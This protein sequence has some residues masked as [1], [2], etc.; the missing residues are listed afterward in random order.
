MNDRSI[1]EKFEKSFDSK[2][3]IDEA[4]NA[5][6]GSNEYKEVPHGEYEVKFKKLALTK[7]KKDSPMV[8]AWME[9]VE[10]QYKGSLI[11]YNQVISSG[12]GLLNAKRFIESLKSGIDIEFKS[13][14][15]FYDLLQEVFEAIDGVSE[16]AL[17]YGEGKNGFNTYE[18]TEVFEV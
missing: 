18:I 4:R 3:L 15:Q 2:G 10:G 8:Q 11:F 13:F 14:P 5:S 9:V 6:E 1:W 16:Y 12:F 17:E 7:S